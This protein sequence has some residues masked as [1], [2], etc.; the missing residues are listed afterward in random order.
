MCVTV[1]VCVCECESVCVCV[2]LDREKVNRTEV[3]GKRECNAV[4]S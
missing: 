1:S 2:S 3:T 4:F